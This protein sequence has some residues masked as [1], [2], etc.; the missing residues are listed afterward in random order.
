MGKGLNKPRYVKERGHASDRLKAVRGGGVARW[1]TV[2]GRKRGVHETEGQLL[3]Q[4]SADLTADD[5]L[6]DDI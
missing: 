2:G 4:A 5:R 6:P 1:R 3:T